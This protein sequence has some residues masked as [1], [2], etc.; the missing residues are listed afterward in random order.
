[1]TEIVQAST[2]TLEFGPFQSSIDLSAANIYFSI[3][4]FGRT[5]LEKSGD[6]S[7]SYEGNKV[8]VSLTQMDTLQLKEGAARVQINLTMNDG[9]VR[10][11]TYEAPIKILHNQIQRV[12]T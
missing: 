4:Q 10:L 8:F 2:Q 5:V 11:P 1:M 12:L 9:S 7:V 3:S 6:S